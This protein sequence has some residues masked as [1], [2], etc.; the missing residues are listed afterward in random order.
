MAHNRGVVWAHCRRE[1]RGSTA[2]TWSFPIAALVAGLLWVGCG[3]S[4]DEPQPPEFN[5][6]SVKANPHMVTAA[7]AEFDVS[8]TESVAVEFSADGAT[9]ESTPEF[10][11]SLSRFPVIGLRPSTE[12]TFRLAAAG[13]TSEPQTLTT[14]KLPDLPV[15][16]LTRPA[17]PPAVAPGYVMI[18]FTGS[19]P[20]LEYAAVIYDSTGRPVW[21]RDFDLPVFDVQRQADGNYTI[22]VVP[23]DGIPY[24]S[25]V[26]PF[27]D[28]LSQIRSETTP[29]TGV[30]EFRRYADGS[31]LLYGLRSDAID[32]SP[33]SGPADAE[34]RN[35]IVEYRKGGELFTWNAGF[36][37]LPTDGLDPLTK[38]VVDPYHVNSIDRDTDGNLLIS[39]RNASQVVKV[40]VETGHVRWR[41]GGKRNEFLF[42]GD[43]LNGFDRQ[44]GA[45]RLPNGNILLFDNGN[46]HTPPVSRAVEYELDETFK[47]ATLV[48]EYR[49]ADVLAD[50]MGFAQRLDN[51]NTLICFG[52]ARVIRE[53]TK[54][55]DLAWQL[56][57]IS[58]EL[59]YRAI[60][61]ESPYPF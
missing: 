32:L 18:G 52:T 33:Y 12:Y 26:D 1:N 34:I 21:Y 36:G 7:I 61:I 24:V 41:L 54:G 51:G 20:T 23:D 10:P 50:A 25:V 60:K 44:H 46:G 57:A 47:V 13:M 14:G 48:W 27:G 29:E 53:V 39:M 15:V 19:D 55:G 16:D 49:V 30:H 59:P 37:M 11:A 38:A 4:P 6:F 35:N 43:Q 5:A 45:R 42:A 58:G 2:L 17:S 56:Q 3:S 31:T 40:D 22:I 8:G 28:V 9:W